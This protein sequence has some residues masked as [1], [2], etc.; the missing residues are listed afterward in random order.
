M[1]IT[2]GDSV[3]GE[4]KP[5]EFPCPCCGYL[6]FDESP[7]SYDICRVCGWE[8]DVS[9]L[10][11]PRTSGGANEVSLIEA[12]ANFAEHGAADPRRSARQA[13]MAGRPRDPHWRPINKTLDHLEDPVPGV[14]Y[15]MTYPKDRTTLYYWRHSFWR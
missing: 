1:V 8:D 7:G 13:A 14:D 6:V 9:Q 15:G 12:Q 11:F 5:A 3:D 2:K 10:R 4:V